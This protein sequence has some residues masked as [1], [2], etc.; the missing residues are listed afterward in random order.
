MSVSVQAPA[1]CASR[2]TARRCPER[3]GRRVLDDTDAGGIVARHRCPERPGRRR[4]LD[5]TDGIL[6]EGQGF[7]SDGQNPG[8]FF[9]S[10]DFW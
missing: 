6:S 4:V 7:L 10:G 8:N 2:G 3:P 9:F 5:D 1:P